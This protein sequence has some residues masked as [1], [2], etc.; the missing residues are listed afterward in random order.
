MAVVE[1]CKMIYEAVRAS[2]M[3]TCMLVCRRCVCVCV[4]ARVCLC[5]TVAATLTYSYSQ[6]VEVHLDLF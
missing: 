5:V 4:C 3:H 1:K 2:F 6:Y